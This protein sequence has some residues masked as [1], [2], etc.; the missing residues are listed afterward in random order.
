MDRASSQS[1][2][3]QHQ[4]LAQQRQHAQTD[5]AT[6]HANVHARGSGLQGLTSVRE[7]DP[8]EAMTDT[9]TTDTPPA[10]PPVSTGVAPTGTTA[11]VPT[12]TTA[13]IPIANALPRATSGSSHGS[14]KRTSP[15]SAHFGMSESSSPLPVLHSPFAAAASQPLE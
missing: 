14:Q 9:P 5:A 1:F 7:E 8:A 3:E 4:R 12:G 13:A 10:P 2:T 11:A 6:G 15:R